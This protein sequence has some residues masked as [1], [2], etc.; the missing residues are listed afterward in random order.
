MEGEAA[1]DANDFVATCKK[2]RV[3]NNVRCV[4][5]G[6]VCVRVHAQSGSL[7]SLPIT[8]T[9]R[10]KEVGLPLTSQQLERGGYEAL[11]ER[12]TLRRQHFLALKACDYLG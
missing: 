4:C 3:L 9:H 11:M 7:S 5:G 1:F 10:R 8:H 12:L 6:V 2:L